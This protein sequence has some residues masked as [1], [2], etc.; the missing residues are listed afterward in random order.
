MQ[1]GQDAFAQPPHRALLQSGG[2]SQAASGFGS[3]LGSGAPQF[4]ECTSLSDRNAVAEL[5]ACFA[6]VIGVGSGLSTPP[7][8]GSG[9][10]GGVA[11][12]E[13]ALCFPACTCA[14]GAG[15]EAYLSMLS[16][17]GFGG[18]VCGGATTAGIASSLSPTPTPS[19]ATQSSTRMPSLGSGSGGGM[20]STPSPSIGAGG[21]SM[22]MPMSGSGSSLGS[23][24]PAS[25]PF[26]E[27]VDVL[28]CPASA[29]NCA[30][31]CISAGF[32]AE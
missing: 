10:P 32:I 17:G 29:D 25:P 11:C 18:L 22:P 28:G 6:A 24:L 26:V 12:E 1:G 21:S 16:C 15:L 4:L 7:A 3:G 2:G 19:P 31:A 27:E 14:N 9:I 20:S 23:F 8:G 5:P 30:F 13:I